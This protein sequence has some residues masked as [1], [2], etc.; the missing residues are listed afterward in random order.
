MCHD[1]WLRR[2]EEALE[3]QWLRE[4]YRRQSDTPA[5]EPAEPPVPAGDR[6]AFAES[7]DRRIALAER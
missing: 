7:V 1:L 2:S 5:S 4:L 6:V 3:A